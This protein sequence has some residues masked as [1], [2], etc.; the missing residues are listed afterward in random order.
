M[1][2]S[3]VA[4]AAIL[5]IC[6]AFITPRLT[7]IPT[8]EGLYETTAHLFVGFLILIPAYDWRQKLGPSRAYGLLGLAL[9]TWEALW[10]FAQRYLTP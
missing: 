6:R 3:I 9:T 2:T 5:A 8:L 4:V 1:K 7:H 10:F